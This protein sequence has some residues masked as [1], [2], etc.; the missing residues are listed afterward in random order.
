MREEV[1]PL[2]LGTLCW[3]EIA[4]GNKSLDKETNACGDIDW[5][6]KDSSP[7]AWPAYLLDDPQ[8]G[9]A[10]PAGIQ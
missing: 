10:D 4:E 5:D 2:D 9:T 7:Y 1:D 3:L 6:K 8:Q